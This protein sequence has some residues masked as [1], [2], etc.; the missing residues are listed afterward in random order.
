MVLSK[1]FEAA[2]IPNVQDFIL[3]SESGL[4]CFFF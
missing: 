3:Y 4:N 1:A 2:K